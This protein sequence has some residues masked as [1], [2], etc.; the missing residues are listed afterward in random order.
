MATEFIKIYDVFLSQISDPIFTE[1]DP[2][3]E[4]KK[5]YL[6]NCIPKF[7]I[8]KSDLSKR[9]EDAFEDDLTDEEI[10][11]LGTM[12]VVEYLSPMII[13]LENMKQ[14]LSSKDFNLKSQSAHLEAL[15][16]IKLDKEREVERL[17]IN[18][19]YYNGKLDELR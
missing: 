5:R 4:L 6:L 1:H 3:D 19:S 18:Y 14:F 17:L 10:L 16:S 13:R 8:C 7:R 12:M 15:R 9:T 2:E 11:I